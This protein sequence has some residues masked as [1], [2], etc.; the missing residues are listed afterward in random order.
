VDFGGVAV[1]LAGEQVNCF[2][3]CLRL[4]F[5]G[6]G[7]APGLAARRAGGLLRGHEYALGVLGGVPAGKV[8]AP[9]YP[10]DR[11]PI[12]RKDQESASRGLS[13]NSPHVSAI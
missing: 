7:G 1:R 10:G 13:L 2:L 3:F 9:A 5:S 12:F 8:R 4:S 6:Q 11:W